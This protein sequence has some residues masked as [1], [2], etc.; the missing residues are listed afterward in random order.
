MQ[1]QGYWR[2]SLL[3]DRASELER[4]VEHAR[5]SLRSDQIGACTTG[6]TIVHEIAA[7]NLYA[8]AIISVLLLLKFHYF[9]R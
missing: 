2:C 9:A 5:A 7:R 4:A 1:Q 3:A 6:A 8:G